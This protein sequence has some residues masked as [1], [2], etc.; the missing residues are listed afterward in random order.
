M[1]L[2]VFNF[3]A[4]VV[5]TYCVVHSRILDEGEEVPAHARAP[6]EMEIEIDEEED[7]N[8]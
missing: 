4:L 3:L 6:Q 2:S 5:C 7:V 8:E 1:V